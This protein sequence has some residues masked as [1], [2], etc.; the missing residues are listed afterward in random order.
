VTDCDVVVIGAGHQ[1][2]VA[3]IVLAEAGLEVVVVE[4]ADSVG[5]AVKSGQ[6]TL[7]GY[8]HDMYAMNMNLFLGSPFYADHAD[9]L[10]AHGLRFATSRQPYASAFPDGSSLRVDSDESLTLAMWA[11]H[12]AADAAGWTRLGRVFDDVASAYLP[13]YGSPL[14]SRSA[15]QAVHAAWRS[16][17]STGLG[18]LSQILLSST[19]ALG[20]R[21]FE[22]REARALVAAWGMHLDYAPDVTAGAIFP[23]LE[24]FLDMRNGM[25]VVQGG[26]SRLPEALQSVVEECGGRV[27]TGEAATRI[28]VEGGRVRAVTL[29]GGESL[30]TRRG[31]I[32]TVVLPVLVR[33]L[34][35]SQVVPES[36][37]AGAERYRFGPGTFMLHLALNGPIPWTDPRLSTS[38]YVHLGPYVDDMA[39]TYQQALSGCLPDEPLL[40]VGQTSVVDPSRVLHPN[41][42]IVWV[43]ARM[44][45][46]SIVNDAGV[47]DGRSLAGS[48]WASARDPF[49][50][51]VMNKLCHYAPGLPELIVAATPMS[52]R[53]LESANANLVGG[54]S[55][56][57]SH[58]LDQ[59]FG[60]RPTLSAARYSTPIEGLYLAGAGTWPG[61]GVNAVSGQL[62]ARKLLS[63]QLRA[64]GLSMRASRAVKRVRTT[65]E[66]VIR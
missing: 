22:T 36:L 44:V 31:V 46:G 9:V 32:S 35:A 65:A 57:G 23:L 59:F 18:E 29:A 2:L 17:K 7:P 5:G 27:A 28:Q 38:A 11:E 14:P 56:A 15:L 26:A 39:R 12:N 66:N 24:L 4:A 41:H 58:H 47:V 20:E 42:H 54:D 55:V 6:I 10:A 61:A 60:L 3:A 34:L 52:P 1:G 40:V 43:Q 16:R 48:S 37:R 13:L 49:A 8:E 51:R 63:Q 50:H 33:D 64:S 45:P 30:R 62:A 53:D 21:Y 19:R 25:S